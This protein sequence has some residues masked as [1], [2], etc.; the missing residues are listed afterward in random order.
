MS[1]VADVRADYHVVFAFGDRHL[2]HHDPTIDALMLS[3][4]DD[5]QPDIIIDGGDMI[6]ADCL[7]RFPKTHEQKIGLQD[8]L[9]K[10]QEWRGKI[11]KVSPHSQKV[12]LL[13]NHFCRRLDDF[14]KKDDNYWVA[15]MRAMTVESMLNTEQYHWDV[16]N[17]WVW[18]DHIMFI[19]GD[20]QGVSG[21]SKC[22]SNKVRQNTR[23][24][25]MSVV[26]FHSHATGFEFIR[27]GKRYHI[28][29]QLGTTMNLDKVDYVKHNS[30]GNTTNSVGLFYLPKPHLEVQ[31][32]TFVPGLIM[33]GRTIL[34]GRIY[35]G[36]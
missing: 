25:M 12:I 34:N 13:D 28:A 9:D 22:P 5:I 26:Q 29:V 14:C 21:T 32:P 6:S 16:V 20:G 8:E 35:T 19:H 18:N 36:N 2:P 17:E 7:S 11:D 23:Q 24:A 10:D 4:I 3:I 31:T 15:D 27:S 1:V 33:G 30:L